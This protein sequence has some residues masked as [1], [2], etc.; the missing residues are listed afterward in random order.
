M[1]LCSGKV[2][3]KV[4]QGMALKSVQEALTRQH[5]Q[6]RLKWFI[7][8]HSFYLPELVAHIINEKFTKAVPLYRQE[9]YFKSKVIP[10]SQNHYI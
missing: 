4:Q 8:S 9:K 2:A 6:Y 10:Y 5:I 7:E 3:L 1:A